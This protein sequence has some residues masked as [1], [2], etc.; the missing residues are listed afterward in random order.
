MRE[1]W[2]TGPQSSVMEGKG[3]EDVIF[4]NRSLRQHIMG[5]GESNH[6]LSVSMETRKKMVGRKRENER[7]NE[8]KSSASSVKQQT[9]FQFMACT[10]DKEMWLTVKAG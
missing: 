9:E 7:F 4:Q 6:L 5:A 10:S 8:P 2:K 1:R 3:M